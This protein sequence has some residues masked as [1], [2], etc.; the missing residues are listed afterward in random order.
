LRLEKRRAEGGTRSFLE[1]LRD[2]GQI[3]AIDRHH[4]AVD[5][6]FLVVDVEGRLR[7]SARPLH[8]RLCLGLTDLFG[9]VPPRHWR[10]LQR[11]LTEDQVVVYWGHS[12]IGENFRLAQIEQHLGPGA[13][14]ITAALRRAPLRLI[15]FLSCYSYMYFGQ[16]LVAAAAERN[17]GWSFVYTGVEAARHES[18][19]LAVLALIDLVLHPV[20]GKG[21][22]D[23]L[24]RLGD[25]EF[26]MVKDVAARPSQ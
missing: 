11:A 19:P 18:G 20:D 14:A 10:I 5:D 13:I 24:P 21:G 4:S 6:G 9:P 16:D 23:K 12:G 8:V 2:L 26:W 7:T 15:A 25:D 22:I 1:V 17:D 3:V